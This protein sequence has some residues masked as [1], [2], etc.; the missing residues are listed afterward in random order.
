[1]NKSKHFFKAIRNPEGK[2]S[3]NGVLMQVLGDNRVKIG[4]DQYELTPEIQKALS[5]TKYDFKNMNDDEIINFSNILKSVN[6]TPDK[7]TYS[8][9]RRYIEKNLQ[10]RVENILNPPMSL[11][12]STDGDLEGNGMKYIIPSN[13]VDIWSKLEVLLDSKIAGHTNTLTFASHLIDELY[14]RGEIETE[15]QYRNALDKFL[16]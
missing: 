8:A 12:E 3:W 10:K 7:D 6:Y 11:E 13:T 15:N 16:K 4:D 1:M 2:L 5:E 9:R 14:K